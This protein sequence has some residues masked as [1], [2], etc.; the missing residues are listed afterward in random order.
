MGINITFL[1]QIIA[2]WIVIAT[3]LT[4]FLAKRKTQTPIIATIIGFILSFIPPVCM[5]YLIVLVLKNDVPKTE[6]PV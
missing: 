3:I 6:V 4:F 5:I 2:V 1:G